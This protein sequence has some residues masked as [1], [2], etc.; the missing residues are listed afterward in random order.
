MWCTEVAAGASLIFRIVV[1]GD[2]GDHKRSCLALDFVVL[3]LSEAVLS[4]TVLVLDGCLNCGNSD[5]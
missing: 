3:V 5:R 4:E 2:I 1:S